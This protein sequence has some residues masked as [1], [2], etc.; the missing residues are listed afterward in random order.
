MAVLQG[1]YEVVMSEAIVDE[2]ARHETR[3]SRKWRKSMYARKQ[4]FRS[5]V[6]R[7]ENLR[8]RIAATVSATQQSDAAKDAHLLEAAL[9]TDKLVS[10]RD[11]QA[12]S[13]FGDVAVKV[14]ELRPIVWVN[15][16]RCEESPIRW[17]SDGARA[18][19]HRMLGAVSTGRS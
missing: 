9:A 18:E 14:Q 3:Y 13:V 2:W 4:F 7:D 8:R 12:R 5:D 16:T 15:P 11:D 1:G 10:S 6:G 17:L 19:P